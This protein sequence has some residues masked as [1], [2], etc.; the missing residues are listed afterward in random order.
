MTRPKGTVKTAL[1][2]LLA[3]LGVAGASGAGFHSMWAP[4]AVIPAPG[5]RQQMLSTYFGGLRGTPA[6]TPVFI[7]EGAEPGG[8][9]LVLGGTHPSEPAGM[10]AAVIL[11]ENARV[12]RG[13]LLVIPFTNIMGFTHTTPQ[14]GHPRRISFSLPAGGTRSFRHGSRL[15][16][17]IYQWPDPDIYVHPGSGQTLSGR[18]RSNLNRCYPGLPRGSVTEKLAYGVVQ[19]I[20]K[21]KVDVTIDLHEASPEYPVV[22]AVVA[23]ERSMELAALV[24]MELESMDIPIRLEP[25]PRNLHGLSHR[26]LGDGTG[27]MPVLMETANPAQGRLH[28]RTDDAL[29][30]TGKDK[31]YVKAR[32]LGILYIPYGGSQPIELRV[33]RHLTG[34]K[35]F[36]EMLEMV[37]EKKAVTVEGIPDF[38]ELVTRGCGAFLS[39]PETT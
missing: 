26:E 34:I 22:N 12:T 38:E 36:M 21:E 9:V 32:E 39:A 29:V 27:T 23:H 35:V 15:T 6:D 2:L 25:S 14:E 33:G 10:L 28:G 31:A 11:V 1:L 13:R 18:E 30:L 20:N 7:Q 3:A 19:L 4:D 8:T 24:A 16:N 17:P 5:F 37:D